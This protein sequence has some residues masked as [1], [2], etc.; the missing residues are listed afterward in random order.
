MGHKEHKVCVCVYYN[1]SVVDFVLNTS[2]VGEE[3]KVPDGLYATVDKS[4]K[5]NG[6]QGAQSQC[7]H[8]SSSTT[9]TQYVESETIREDNKGE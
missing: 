1:A 7:V 8:A 5:K 4:K 6:P 2:A 9:H 3:R